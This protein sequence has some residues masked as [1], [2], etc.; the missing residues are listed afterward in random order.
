MLARSSAPRPSSAQGLSE[1]YSRL[2]EKYFATR[3]I[4][5]MLGVLDAAYDRSA[6]N[7]A[8]CTKRPAMPKLAHCTAIR[9]RTM[10]SAT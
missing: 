8:V 7:C 4:S 2:S 3:L 5:A 10:N 6:S 9:T 1:A